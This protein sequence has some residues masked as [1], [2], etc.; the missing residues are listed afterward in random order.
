M[1]N[2][3]EKPTIETIRKE[4]QDKTEEDVKIIVDYEKLTALF[5][6]NNVEI[7]KDEKYQTE[8][9]VLD[10][11]IASYGVRKFMKYDSGQLYERLKLWYKHLERVE[12]F[13]AVKCNPNPVLLQILA[14]FGVRFDVASLEEI[15]LVHGLIDPKEVSN[16]IIFAN[17]I[18]ELEHIEYASSKNIKM[19]TF[20]NK[21]E[22][23]KIKLAHSTSKLL[24]RIYVDDSRSIMPL[25][26]K[27]GCRD[28]D[29]E[30]L[31][32]LA[33]TLELE[34]VGVSFH[35]GSGCKDPGA[36]SD[37]IIQARKV[38]TLG[39]KYNHH[40]KILDIGGGFPGHSD[41]ES[42]NK[43]IEIA[44]IINAQ[45][46]ESFSDV[47]GLRVIA[48]PGR[49]FAT[50]CGTMVVKII[51]KNIKRDKIT[52]KIE[53]I[54]YTVNSSIYGP[55]NNVVFDNSKIQFK[56]LY[57]KDDCELFKSVIWGQTCDSC[58]KIAKE[59]SL[60]ELDVGSWLYAENQGAYTMAS[61]SPFNGFKLDGNEIKWVCLI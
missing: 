58:D 9:A 10:D 55:F 60:P 53:R 28:D 50:S 19:M 2:G 26:S 30:E 33:N 40:M 54:D 31:L 59:I 34:I 37:A 3:K 49:F 52:K 41:Q 29:L 47:K 14:C 13:Y 36:Y 16:N 56:L 48:E 27:F 22:L 11:I 25:G 18:K 57:E 23:Y 5:S 44:S 38:F 8:Q 21:Y 39:E 35:V 51:S 6:E 12:P 15:A 4:I 20:D 42:I 17:P 32:T 1:S 46:D 43:F 7:Y 24:I 45:L 61:A